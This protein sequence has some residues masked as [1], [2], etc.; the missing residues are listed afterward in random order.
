MAGANQETRKVSGIRK[1]G[2][3]SH[4][5][6]REFRAI[7][8]KLPAEAANAIVPTARVGT[9]HLGEDGRLSM[10]YWRDGGFAHRLEVEMPRRCVRPEGDAPGILGKLTSNWTAL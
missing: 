10:R 5:Q 2:L 9:V 3:N 7:Q 8:M 6:V 4:T 1:Q